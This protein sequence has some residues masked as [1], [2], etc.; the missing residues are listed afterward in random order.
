MANPYY[1]PSGT[2]ATASQGAS[3]AIRAEFAAI[4]TAFN[5]LPTLAGNAN[6]LVQVNGSGTGLIAANAINGVVI[7]ATTPAA[8]T[9]TSLAT[10]TLSATGAVTFNNG[11]NVSGTTALAVATATT[12]ITTDN[13]T[14]VAT[15]AWVKGQGYLTAVGGYLSTSGGTLTGALQGTT[16][17]MSPTGTNPANG[18]N[19]F[20]LRASGSFGGGLGLLDG[21]FSIALYSNSGVLNFGF[22]NGSG[23]TGLASAA[24]LTSAGAFTASSFNATSSRKYKK[25]VKPLRAQAAADAIERLRPVTYEWKSGT[26]QAGRQDIGFIAEEVAKVLPSVVAWDDADAIGVD[27]GRLT[28]VLVAEMQQLRRRVAELERGR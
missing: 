24:T 3:A 16:V 18:V 5:L 15:T 14:N 10:T 13:S 23:A 17:L 12:P 28:T 9:F 19:S 21:T 6:A 11:L 20:A 1:N 26:Q 22:A 25:N 7:G 2:P 27:Y 4:S 8:G